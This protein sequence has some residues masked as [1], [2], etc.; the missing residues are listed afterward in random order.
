MSGDPGDL[1]SHDT[2]DPRASHPALAIQALATQALAIETTNLT[3]RF[4]GIT[5]VEAVLNRPV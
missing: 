4:D 1:R 2:V 5:A 3:R